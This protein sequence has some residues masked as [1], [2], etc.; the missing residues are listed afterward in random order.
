MLTISNIIIYFIFNFSNLIHISNSANCIEKTKNIYSDIVNSIGVS[1]PLPP[2]LIFSESE[3]NPAYISNKGIVI[4]KKLIELF[5]EEDNFESKIAYVISHEL[6]HHLNYMYENSGFGI[7]AQLGI[8]FTI[9]L[10]IKSKKLAESQ[11]TFLEVFMV[12]FPD[13]TSFLMQSLQKIYEE[14]K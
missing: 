8:I 3:N 6:A 14:Y 1:F 9:N 5:C 13:M 11:L 10:E 7:L 12:K 4:E 2:E